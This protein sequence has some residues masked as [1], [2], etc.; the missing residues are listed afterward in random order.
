[1]FAGIYAISNTINNKIY[2]GSTNDLERRWCEHQHA[3]RQNKHGNCHLQSSWDKHGEKAFEFIVL[4]CLDDLDELVKAEQFW[5]DFYREGG[6]ELYN[7]GM[8]ADNP[9]RGRT[10]TEEAKRKMCEAR[11]N[12]SPEAREARSCKQ[13][14][15]M[16]GNQYA[17][18]HSHTEETKSRL[19]AM[20]KG[21]EASEETC[22]RMCLAAKARWEDPEY[23]EVMMEV[24]N[25]PD[26]IEA[27][28]KSSKARWA[29]P[30]FR[31][32][33]ME[34]HQSE[35]VKTNKSKA[36]TLRWQDPPYRDKVY[37]GLH[38]PECHTRLVAANRE[39]WED[40]EY[41]SKMYTMYQSAEFRDKCNAKPY[42]AFYNAETG[43]IIP[44]G[45]N[46]VRMC[47]E[48]E[49]THYG[50]WAVKMGRQKSS[51]G[52]ILQEEI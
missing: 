30:D 2:I 13:R 5:M 26:R 37:D 29:D 27:I 43:E 22:Q 10:H 49:L 35:E 28:S 16:L 7:F 1:M 41:S 50:M 12:T 39:R 45:I 44:A 38:T 19:S 17:L 40:E 23:R 15:F 24:L 25:D 14:E 47:Q 8:A 48:H 52:W 31:Q 6:K 34:I 4:E 32:K 42:P 9:M 33:M 11:Y 21:K 18:G 51:Q 36:T 3:L 20:F 46:L